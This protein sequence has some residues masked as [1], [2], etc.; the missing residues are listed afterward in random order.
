MIYDFEVYT[1]KS[2]SAYQHLRYDEKEGTGVLVLPSQR[3]LR[4]YRNFIR[5]KRG[6]NADIITEL[7][8]KTANFSNEEKFVVISFDEMKVQ[9]D[10]VWD[11]HTNELIGFVDLGD[12][13]M[14]FS[15]FKE[16]DKIATHVLVFLIKSVVNPLSY[17][18]AT[19]ATTGVTSSQLFM[20]F[21]RAVAILEMTCSL[22]VIAV[23]CDGASP[24]RSF[25]RMHAAYTDEANKEVVY[26]A[27]N[28]YANEKRFIWFFC[29]APHLIKTA[30]NCLS[31]SGAGR[32]SRYM[33][34]NGFFLLWT[35][36][37]KLYYED[38]DC[39]LR[40]LP[41]LTSD[42]INLTPYS[43]MR[44]KLAVQI[45]SSTVSGVLQLG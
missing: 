4:D 45:L 1:G 16:A 21:W 3:T 28:L 24:N 15:T 23:T 2:P 10:L 14:N 35:H 29:D 11:K 26:R 13:A 42:H 36:I 12:P 5:P 22:K 43:V 40:L 6:F 9:E 7:T 8:K 41:H 27:L 31:N 38:A 19:F 30:R 39:G 44:V 32:N 18:L 20:L 37:S 25:Y 34:N 33:W 17:S